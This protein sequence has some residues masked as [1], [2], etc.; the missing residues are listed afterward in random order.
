MET[1]NKLNGLANDIV[2]LRWDNQFDRALQLY[3]EQVAPVFEKAEVAEN[4]ALIGAVCDCLKNTDQVPAAIQFVSGYLHLQP[5]SEKLHLKLIINLAWLY[6]TYLHKKI[7]PPA[8]LTHDQILQ[9]E[10][11]IDRLAASKEKKVMNL[12]FFALTDTLLSQNPQAWQQVFELTEKFEATHFSDEEGK[13]SR[14]TS[15]GIKEESIASPLEKWWVLRVKARYHT[16]QFSACIQLGTELLDGQ[17]KKFHHG[18]HIWITRLIAKSFQQNGK[19][20][21]AIHQ[22]EL[23]LKKRREWFIQMELAACYVQA[24]M[25]SEAIRTFTDAYINGGHSAYKVG[26]YEQMMREQ[27]DEQLRNLLHH[28]VIKTRRD[29]GWPI[30]LKLRM[31]EESVM[32]ENAKTLYEQIRKLLQPPGVLINESGSHAK[33]DKGIITRIL[34]DTENGDGFITTDEGLSVYFRF[35]QCSIPYSQLKTGLAVSFKAVESGIGDG[36]RWQAKKV[37]ASEKK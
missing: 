27:D 33:H 29:E 26:L 12:L 36:N 35:S 16:N 32:D 19:I 14:K 25:K 10:A 30:P 22:L 28:L 11:L 9:C 7:Y 3:K 24:Q 6:F 21:Q 23:I 34:H 15:S 1:E 4:N 37:F 31:N 5:A 13:I 2:K 17:I 20:Q 18:N 8:K